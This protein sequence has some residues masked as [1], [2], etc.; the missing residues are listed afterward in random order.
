MHLVKYWDR[1]MV[2]RCT[3]TDLFWRHCYEDSSPIVVKIVWYICSLNLVLL[4]SEVFLTFI[5]EKKYALRYY[6]CITNT[7]CKIKRRSFWEVTFP[8]RYMCRL[9]MH[10]WVSL[11]VKRWCPWYQCVW[12]V[13]SPHV[14]WGCVFWFHSISSVEL[15]HFSC[16]Y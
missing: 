4:A 1:Y 12:F 6:R 3:E 10:M 8:P 5:S 9:Y 2:H 15:I 11:L 13:E 14:S 7:T 16:I